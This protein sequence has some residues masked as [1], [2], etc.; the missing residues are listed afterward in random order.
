MNQPTATLTGNLLVPFSTKLIFRLCMSY[1]RRK[2]IPCLWILHITVQLWWHLS[3]S[4]LSKLMLIH[5][6]LALWIPGSN[7][8]VHTN[9][10]ETRINSCWVSSWIHT[11]PTIYHQFNHWSNFFRAIE[12]GHRCNF[13]DWAAFT[14]RSCQGYWQCFQEI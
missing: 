1:L 2:I 8:T 9:C 4:H 13:D 6:W 10:Q 5:T 12:R 14:P 11:R 7:R 3:N